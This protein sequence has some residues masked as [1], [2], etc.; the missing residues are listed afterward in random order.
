VPLITLENVRLIIDQTVVFEALNAQIQPGLIAVTGDERVG[1]TTLLMLLAGQHAPHAGT[2]IGSPAF[3]WPYA[4][5][6]SDKQTP[7]ERWAQAA[8]VAPAWNQNLCES[9][10]SALSLNEH[11]HKGL[12]MLSTGSRR[13]VDLIANLASGAEVTCIDQPYVGLDA[14]SISVLRDFFEEAREAGKRSQRAWVIADY[15]ADPHLNWDQT[16]EL[17]G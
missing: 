13:K 10:C 3:F 1:K 15:E 16:I 2:H 17:T 6:E 9:L 11:Q 12:F 14:P 4:T 5:A 8:R 7:I